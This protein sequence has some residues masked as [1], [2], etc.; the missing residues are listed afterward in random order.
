M[1]SQLGPIQQWVLEHLEAAVHDP[2]SPPWIPLT[3]LTA[4]HAGGP[5]RRRE[6]ESMRRACHRLARIGL[7]ETSYRWLEAQPDR[8]PLTRTARRRH[9]CVRLAATLSPARALKQEQ[10]GVR[11]E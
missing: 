9:L 7:V 8:D 1:V 2:R 5:P 11:A 6:I 4:E 3:Q 10:P